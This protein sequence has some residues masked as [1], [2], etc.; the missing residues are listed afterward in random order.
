MRTSTCGLA[1]AVALAVLAGCSIAPPLLSP[2]PVDAAPF[3]VLVER[4]RGSVGKLLSTSCA[5]APIAG[6]GFVVA[7]GLMLTGAHVVDGGRQVSLRL[8]GASPVL[9]DIVGIDPAKDTALVRARVPLDVPPLA[10]AGAPVAP[11]TP[12]TTLGYPLGESVLRTEV[13][14][15]TSVTDSAIV[16]DRPMQDLVTVDA[17]I[18]TGSS[19]GPALAADGRVHGMVVAAIGGRGGRDSAPIVALAIPARSLADSLAAWR[20]NPPDPGDGCAG[21]AAR[22]GGALDLDVVTTDPA[23]AEFVHTLWLLGKGINAGQAVSTWGMLS[24]GR[25]AAE[26]GPEA[27]AATVGDTRWSGLAV[28]ATSRDGDRATARVR[29][30]STVAG[31]CRVQQLDVGLELVHGIWLVGVA[32]PAGDAESCG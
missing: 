20:G 21:E 24:A 8:T 6:S 26:G 17:T 31:K 30:R 15:I 4:A 14:R 22:D 11:G 10:L 27:W 13:S 28:L 3:A 23:A 32:D 5:G 25:R 16:N 18:R 7:P 12:V 9:A 2:T 19:G 29:L 1:A